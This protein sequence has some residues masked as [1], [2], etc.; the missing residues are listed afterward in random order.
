VCCLQG[1]W[2]AGEVPAQY[3][4][5]RILSVGAIVL[6]I[7]KTDQAQGRTAVTCIA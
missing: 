4:R 6:A 5:L 3:L 2:C 7:G 1:A